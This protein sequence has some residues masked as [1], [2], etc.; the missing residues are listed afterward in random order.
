MKEYVQTNRKKLLIFIG[1]LIGIVLLLMPMNTRHLEVEYETTPQV[2]LDS[3]KE[4]TVEEQIDYTLIEKSN[5]IKFFANTFLIDENVL[6]NK[7]REN[8]Q[9]LNYLNDSE[10]FDMIVLN[11]LISL[12]NTD[13]TLFNSTRI[14]NTMNKDYIVKVLRYFCNLY[15]NVDFSIAAG[16]AQIESGFTSEYM[17]YKNNIY[18][19]MYSGG[20]IGYKTIEYGVLK[21]VILLNDGYFSKGH[22]TI[23]AIG[24]IFNPTLN[25]EGIKVAK[26]IWVNN[27]TNAMNEFINVE[28]VDTN[29]L[30]GLKNT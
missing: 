30:I 22:N 28:Y 20:L 25:D 6:I 15:P 13:K 5:S 10:N 2:N 17:L 18:G 26:P 11:Y 16:I 12:E 29:V 14:A 1:G 7:L 9:V 21:Y 4:I 3:Q 24:K 27:V 8:Y 23:D 19:G